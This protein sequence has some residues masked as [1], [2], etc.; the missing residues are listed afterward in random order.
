M[1]EGV[2]PLDKKRKHKNLSIRAQIRNVNAKILGLIAFMVVCSITNLLLLDLY[3]YRQNKYAEIG[4]EAR[5]ILI[6]QYIWLNTLRSEQTPEMDSDVC[7][8]GVWYAKV[9]D[10]GSIDKEM[11]EELESAYVSHKELHE[12]GQEYI[13]NDWSEKEDK[14]ET[15]SAGLFDSM[16][17]ISNYYEEKAEKSHSALV[18]R[19]I[20]AIC[21]SVVLSV[22]TLILARK[23]GDKMAHKIAAPIA[24]VADWSRELSMGSSNLEFDITNQAQTD[25]EEVN[26][27]V[28]SFRA[29]ADSIQENVQVVKKVADGDMTAFVNI[30]SS[31]D[32]LGKNLYRMVQSNDLMFAEISKIADSVAIGANH[33]S[34]ASSALAESCTVQAGAVKDFTT[35]IEETG[36][37]IYRNNKKA[38]RALHVSNEIQVEIEESTEKMRH[39]LKAMVD[40][41]QASEKVS[42][43]IKTI[44][45]IASQTNLLA[46]N[47]AIEAARAGEAGKGFAVV[48]G[49]VKDLAAKSLEAAEESKKLIQDTVDKT[50]FGDKISQ[51]TSETFVKITDSISDITEITQEIAKAGDE[52]QKHIMAVKEHIGAIS[53]AIDENAAA[54]QEAAAASDELNRDGDLLKES[55]Q[56]FNLRKRE[57]G[58]PYIPPE[59]Q[60]DP[61]F[62]REAE[63]NYQK[64]LMDGK[65]KS[66]KKGR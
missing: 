63:E 30:R 65:L 54:S 45:D 31:S 27:M 5:E 36:N 2:G 59:K 16:H 56:K 60:N 61:A 24:A 20:W 42:V 51:E 46:L 21:T 18:S 44:D 14:L 7:S 57:E 47:A 25:L 8:F 22:L 43:I 49:E 19:I 28:E 40:I 66:L 39:L 3:Q 53:G 55:M 35:V 13:E 26:A 38:E 4:T 17:K 23:L 29:M 10:K 11:H 6:Q 41:R 48:A 62:I 9:T 12:A 15:A 34:E 50:M 58:K 37:F 52:Q 33:I 1:R 32:S 64:A